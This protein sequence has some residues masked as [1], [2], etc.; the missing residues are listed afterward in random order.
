MVNMTLFQIPSCLSAPQGVS[1]STGLEDFTDQEY[2]G[3]SLYPCTL[4]ILEW[5]RV[6]K[7]GP[8]TTVPFLSF[9]C[10]PTGGTKVQE[11]ALS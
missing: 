6:R 3:I 4:V 10:P 1:S 8:G 9:V 7:W 11:V 2:C 5:L